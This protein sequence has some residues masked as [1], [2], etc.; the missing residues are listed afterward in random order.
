MR[1][2]NSL[3][4]MISEGSRR[5]GDALMKPV[6]QAG[7][8]ALPNL[9]SLE[10]VTCPPRRLSPRQDRPIGLDDIRRQ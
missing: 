10:G 1:D 6:P 4:K 9:P 2:S 3:P 5:Y 8:K 7:A